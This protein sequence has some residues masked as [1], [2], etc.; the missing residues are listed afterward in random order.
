MCVCL[1]VCVFVCMCVYVHVHARVYIHVGVSNFGFSMFW[2]IML[3]KNLLPD[4]EGREE[5]S[6]Y[7]FMNIY[8]YIYIYNT[9]QLSQIC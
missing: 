6:I 3:W 4:M 2:R 5:I 9:C 8:I 1:Y 7:M